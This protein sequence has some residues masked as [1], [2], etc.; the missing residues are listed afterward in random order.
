[1]D[2]KLE[3]KE[4]G[5]WYIVVDVKNKKVVPAYFETLTGNVLYLLNKNI[6]DQNS[7]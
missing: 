7:V 6:E 5:Y 2:I 4:D 1:M 3:D